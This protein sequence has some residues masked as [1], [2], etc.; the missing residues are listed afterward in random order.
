MSRDVRAYIY[1]NLGKVISGTLSESS[2]VDSGLIR[3]SG[4]LVLDGIYTPVRGSTVKL[5]Y[6]KQG[7]I[8]I[9]GRSLRVLGYYAN[10]VSRETQVKI[11]CSLTYHSE[12]VSTE[13]VLSSKDTADNLNLNE[14]ERL[15]TISPTSAATVFNRC[16]TI[17]GI[18]RAA[19][20][21]TN[22]FYTEEFSLDGSLIDTMSDL[23]K[24]ENY[25]GYMDSSNVLQYINLAAPVNVGAVLNGDNLIEINPTTSE[26]LNADVVFSNV[27]YRS[28]RLDDAISETPTSTGQTTSELYY[29]VKKRSYPY[30]LSGFSRDYVISRRDYRWKNPATGLTVEDSIYWYPSTDWVADYDEQGRLISRIEVK[31][32]PWGDTIIK[33]EVLYSFEKGAETQIEIVYEASPLEAVIEAIGYPERML[34]PLPENIFKAADRNL[35]EGWTRKTVR[36]T[37]DNRTSAS[38]SLQEYTLNC[39]TSDGSASISKI[40]ESYESINYAGLSIASMIGLAVKV[41][42]DKSNFTSEVKPPDFNLNEGSNVAPFWPTTTTVTATSVAL[43]PDSRATYVTEVTE[44]PE[45]IFSTNVSGGIVLEFTPPYVSDDKVTRAGSGFRV[46]RSDAAAKSRAYATVQNKLRLGQINGQSVVL[47]IEYRPATPFSAVYLD[48]DNVIGQFR[49]DQTSIAFDNTGILFSADCLFWG[50]IGE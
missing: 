27:S 5:A 33:S 3:V 45:I 26:A 11:G 37:Y 20:P 24:S 50:G 4:E 46:V 6:Y 1:C 16:C 43:A 7:N 9:I 35:I 31:N 8:G 14:I 44:R 28:V 40:F 32:G 42:L 36:H 48:F 18:N 19:C 17:L 12:T 34:P 13:T 39:F 47:P 25:V 22:Q 30:T 21:L 41:V 38:T 2:I 23:L 49:Y 29:N 10:P 15:A